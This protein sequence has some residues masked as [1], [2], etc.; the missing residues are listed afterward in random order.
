[1][2]EAVSAARRPARG[3]Y[4]DLAFHGAPPLSFP[5]SPVYHPHIVC[6]G[7]PKHGTTLIRVFQ[8]RLV[9]GVEPTVQEKMARARFSARSEAVRAPPAT[10]PGQ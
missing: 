2:S 3:R 4:A 1:M 8:S 10:P 7:R 6:R 9:D 5:A